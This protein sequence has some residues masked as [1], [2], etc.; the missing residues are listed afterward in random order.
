VCTL[1]VALVDKTDVY[2]KS[3]R[4]NAKKL[5]WAQLVCF[6]REQ[7]TEKCSF[8][9][10]DPWLVWT[11]LD[12]I[13]SSIFHWNYYYSPLSLLLLLLLLLLY[14]PQCSD[15]KNYGFIIEL[16][17]LYVTYSREFSFGVSDSLAI[18]T[19]P[20]PISTYLY[21]VWPMDYSNEKFLLGYDCI[22]FVQFCSVLDFL[23]FSFGWKTTKPA[24]K[25]I[26]LSGKIILKWILNK[27]DGKQLFG[28]V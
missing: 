26:D 3:L 8:S 6:S 2:R 9:I 11:I 16:C 4:Q 14:C 18:R 21:F 25:Y 24:V 22:L 10:S 27:C 17:Y 1:L 23:E 7:R 5:Y 15:I 13:Q 28:F 12:Q 19:K 20:P